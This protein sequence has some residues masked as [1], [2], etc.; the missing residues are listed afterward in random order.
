MKRPHHAITADCHQ[1]PHKVE[2]D[3]WIACAPFEHLLNMHIIEAKNGGAVLSM[4]F[5]Y[6]YAQGAGLMHG[7]AL[8]SL[9]DTA[10]VMAIKSLLPEQSHFATI[11]MAS[12][13]LYPVKSGTVTAKAAVARREERFIEG[14]AT[15]YNADERPVFRFSSV[16]KIA[17]DLKIR[18][19]Y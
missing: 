6:E 16:F 7:G 12:E 18:Q 19:N 14:E 17:R 1:G 11:R 13:F 8:V 10:V 4:P 15:V 3:A 2:L 5:C 9:A